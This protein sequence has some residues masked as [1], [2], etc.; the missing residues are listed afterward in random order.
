MFMLTSHAGAAAAFVRQFAE[1]VD[2]VFTNAYYYNKPGSIVYDAA[3]EVEVSRGEGGL[4]GCR[5]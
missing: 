5:E 3:K 2:L 4:V 1:D